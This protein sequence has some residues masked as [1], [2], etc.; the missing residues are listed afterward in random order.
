MAF[1]KKIIGP[2][3]TLIGISTAHWVYGAT[4]L[5]WLA[6][7][8]AVGLALDYFAWMVFSASV[9]GSSG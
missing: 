1:I 9:C 7:M 5:V 8:M 6:S 2:D 3:E 4:G